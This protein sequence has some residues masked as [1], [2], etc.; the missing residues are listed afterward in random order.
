MFI[1]RKNYQNRCISV[2]D[3][4]VKVKRRILE[5]N[6]LKWPTFCSHDLSFSPNNNP[7][8]VLETSAVPEYFCTIFI[9]LL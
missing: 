7:E 9:R 6:R 2:D 1:R 8:I 5:F 4:M 3:L